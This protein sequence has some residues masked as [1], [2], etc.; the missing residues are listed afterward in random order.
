M[1]TEFEKFGFYKVNIDYVKYLSSKDGQVFYDGCPNYVRKP[2]LGLL[3]NVG[4]YTYCIPLTSAKQR[5][6]NWSNITEHNYIIYENVKHSELHQNDVYKKI[7]SELYK[8]VLAVLE[9]RKMIP[10]S[11]DLCEYIDFNK[12][13]DERYKDLLDKEYNFLKPYKNDILEKAESLYNKQIESKV[14]KSCYCNF[15]LLE[16]ALKEYI[17]KEPIKEIAIASENEKTSN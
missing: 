10:V 3:T 11:I 15:K 8:K 1:N 16:A 2:F 9:I 4:G 13:T 5:Q 6:L 12:E 14:V 7:S 17:I